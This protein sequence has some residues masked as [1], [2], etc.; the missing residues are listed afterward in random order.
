MSEIIKGSANAGT[1][2]KSDTPCTADVQ[3]KPI[4]LNSRMLRMIFLMCRGNERDPSRTPYDLYSAAAA[5]GYRR[6]AARELAMSPAFVEAY[7]RELDGRGNA[8]VIPT[9]DE[10][11]AMERRRRDKS[12][13]PT[14]EAIAA[15]AQPA[16]LAPGYLIRLTPEGDA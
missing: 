15:A 13:R 7:Q 4:V 3:R 12:A 2:R 9:L 11:Q 5:V 14:A 16:P 6:K 10:I 1:T 8:G